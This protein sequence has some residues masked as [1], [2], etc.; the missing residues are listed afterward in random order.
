MIYLFQV[1]FV[2]AENTS[3]FGLFC[4]W[5]LLINNM[6]AN[7]MISFVKKKNII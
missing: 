1:V 5:Q 6:I 4:L 3:F 7:N 2:Y